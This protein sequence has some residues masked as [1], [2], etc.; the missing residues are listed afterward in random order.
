MAVADFFTRV[1]G[2]KWIAVSGI[3]GKTVIV[4]FRGDGGRDIGR[5]A[6]AAFMTWAR[7]AATAIWPVQNFRFQPCPRAS[8][9]RI[10][11]CNACKAASCARPVPL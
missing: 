10:S 1:H 9:P 11:C 8:N 2:L 7:P 4:I 3:V 5:L 6:D